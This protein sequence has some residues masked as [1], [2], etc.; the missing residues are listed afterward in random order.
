MGELAP[1]PGY[2]EEISLSLC[3]S[4]CEPPPGPLPLPGLAPLCSLSLWL[5]RPPQPFPWAPGLSLEG[6]QSCVLV[7]SLPPIPF[8]RPNS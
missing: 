3:L 7:P 4:A 2:T 5:Q 1:A 8:L 6:W